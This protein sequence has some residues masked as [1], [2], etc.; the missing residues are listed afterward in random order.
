MLNNLVITLATN[1]HKHVDQ[2]HIELDDLIQEAR[3]G[4][5]LVSHL[6]TLVDCQTVNGTVVNYVKNMARH[7]MSEHVANFSNSAVLV[8]HRSYYR[9]GGLQLNNV[10]LSGVELVN[11]TT[12]E[13]EYINKEIFEKIM[14][15]IASFVLTLNRQERF[16]FRRRMWTVVPH[17]LQKISDKLNLSKEWIR[18]LEIVVRH[19][20][21]SFLNRRM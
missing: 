13:S 5:M 11:E 8:P 1:K 9:S 17:T 18:Q 21:Q 4:L 15:N 6:P 3:L 10:S 19:R 14:T 2:T 16:I 7:R 12:P 20:M